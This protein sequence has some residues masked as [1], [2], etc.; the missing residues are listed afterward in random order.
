MMRKKL[1]GY[2][3]MS[4]IGRKLSDFESQWAEIVEEDK[5]IE[6]INKVGYIYTVSSE[7]IARALKQT[8]LSLALLN[9]NYCKM[10]GLPM[11]RHSTKYKRLPK[12]IKRRNKLN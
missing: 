11:R 12:K 3:E 10:H 1:K 8:A 9:N 4:N 7:D 5:I 2:G 6:A